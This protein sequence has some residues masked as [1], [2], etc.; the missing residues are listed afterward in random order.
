MHKNNALLLF[1]LICLVIGLLATLTPLSD[2][3]DDGL[4]DSLVTEGF[5]LMPLLY[6]IIG[7]FFLPTR[8]TS[9][10]LA[11]PKLFPSLLILPPIFN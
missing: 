3:D 7:L 4:L 11:A 10:R 6:S 9:A 8:L 2:I 1:T 5:I